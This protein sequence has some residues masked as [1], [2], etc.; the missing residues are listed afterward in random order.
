MI[1]T[2]LAS[3]H[4]AFIKIRG[5]LLFLTMMLLAAGEFA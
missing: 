2:A 4:E 3:N 1:T 5:S